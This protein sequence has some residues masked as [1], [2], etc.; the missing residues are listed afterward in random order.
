VT[1]SN[2]KVAE[3]V[4]GNFVAAWFNRSPGFCN[5]SDEAEKSIFQGASEAFLTKN[6]CTFVLTPEGKVFHYV[7][8]YV[9]PELFLEFLDDALALR[10]TGFDERMRLKADGLER[11][12]KYHVVLAAGYETQAK[13]TAK[14]PE[15]AERSYRDMTHRHT[16][17]CAW[18]VQETWRYLGRVHR[19]WEKAP[20]LPALDDVRYQY[21]YGNDFSEEGPGASPIKR[22]PTLARML[23]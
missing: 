2:K 16:D 15:A 18:Q 19:S 23:R 22:D 20:A 4:N 7:A 3:V 17:A 9:S 21:L 10:R 5:T 11:L 6:I 14:A 12:R 13:G 1:F 8:G